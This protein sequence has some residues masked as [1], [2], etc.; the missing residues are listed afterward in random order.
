[1]QWLPQIIIKF[2]ETFKFRIT[3]CQNEPLIFEKQPT[4]NSINDVWEISKTRESLT[5]NCNG[6]H[7]VTYK[8]S[9]SSDDNCVRKWG[10]DV[11]GGLSFQN[12]DSEVEN[13]DDTA[14]DFYRAGFSAGNNELTILFLHLSFSFYSSNKVQIFCIAGRSSLGLSFFK[15]NY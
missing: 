3:Q 9:I 2:S 11:V 14:S 1:M 7:L 12:G 13:F 6:Q 15:T 8:F 10:G 4:I 5:I